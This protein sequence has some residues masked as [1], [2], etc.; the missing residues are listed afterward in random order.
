MEVINF[1]EQN[2]IIN[3]YMSELRDKSYQKN[4][5]TFRHNVERIGELMAYE[6]S[7]KLEYKPK[8]VTT[9][10]GTLDI[11]L[12]KDDIILGT[13]LRAG[14][15]FHQGFLNIFDRADNAYVS[16]FRMYINREH[17]EVGIQTIS[18]PPA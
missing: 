6:V 4:R 13:V 16:A 14:L 7:K 3:Q 18:Q 5:L 15:P 10:L 9:P 1:S 8:T 2:S 11:P 12:P 17:T